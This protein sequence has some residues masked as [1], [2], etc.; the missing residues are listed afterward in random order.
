LGTDHPPGLRCGHLGVFMI[1]TTTLLVFCSTAFV[2]IIT[3]GP[4]QI[5][6]ATRSAS[7]ERKAGLMSVLGVSF[8]T[9]IH[10]LAASIGLSAL[11]VSSAPAFNIVK[12]LGA[13]YLIYLGLRTWLTDTDGQQVESAKP[14]GMA[15][16]CFQGMLT[17][18]LNPKTAL[19]FLA[20]L[21]QFVDTAHGHIVGQMMF[22]GVILIS[23]G[24]VVD[25]TV[26]LMADSAG[27]WLRRRTKV[28][29][30]QK[31]V[32]G[33]VYVTLGVGTAFTGLERR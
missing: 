24:V 33:G 9:L 30:V 23:I 1:D 7:Q 8:G 11:L 14:A 4:N 3:P 10:V 13:A 20:F 6:I 19:F 26:A 5:Y 21:P 17:N 25:S 22:L 2:I 28:P 12:Y 32:T 29:Q 18:V 15:R 16:I 27:N 31:W